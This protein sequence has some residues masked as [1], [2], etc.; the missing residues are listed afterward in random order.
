MEISKKRLESFSDGVIAIIITIMVLNIPLPKAF[1]FNSILNFLGT[2]F[3]YFL[4][5]VV[6]GYFWNRHH[7]SFS[8]IKTV[9]AKMIWYNLLF[10]FFLSLIPVLTKWVMENPNNITPA[11]GYDIA[12][13]CVN[14]MYMLIFRMA[15]RGSDNEFI[16]NMRDSREKFIK[17]ENHKRVQSRFIK[18]FF[19]TVIA[20]VAV[21]IVS[22]I[23]RFSSYVL[24]GLPV[25]FSLINLVFENPRHKAHDEQGIAGR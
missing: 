23:F 24:L 21:I 12:Y 17:D 18:I 13:L 3:I 4:S 7:I 14:L 19:L 11:I 10:L 6:V 1:G 9:S 22:I 15:V 5:F 8:Y 16:V 25:L 20:V 2:V